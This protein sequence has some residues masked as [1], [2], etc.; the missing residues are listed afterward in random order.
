MLRAGLC[1]LLPAALCVPAQAQEFA[2]IGEQNSYSI[3]ATLERELLR[4]SYAELILAREPH[5]G[6]VKVHTREAGDG[7]VLLA[8]HP[9]F[10][11]YACASGG[12]CRAVQRWLQGRRELLANAEIVRVGLASRMH[13]RGVY[14][15][16]VN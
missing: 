12:L 8:R 7:Y 11:R 13:P 10:T 15:F 5:L 14:W 9:A 3:P 16:D 4:E 2:S 1:L 6:D